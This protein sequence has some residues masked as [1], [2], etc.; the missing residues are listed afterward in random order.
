MVWALFP[1]IPGI[2][3]L[4]GLLS[5]VVFCHVGLTWVGAASL[6][7]DSCFITVFRGFWTFF[8]FFCK[9]DDYR[10]VRAEDILTNCISP[11]VVSPHSFL[12]NGKQKTGV[13]GSLCGNSLKISWYFTAFC[14][15]ISITYGEGIAGVGG[16]SGS[17]SRQHMWMV[18]SSQ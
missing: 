17:F 15:R 12:A 3:L 16:F 6:S 18:P 2:F 5:Q 10:S 13:P 4:C 7:S 1:F 14:L 9:E 8:F 11:W